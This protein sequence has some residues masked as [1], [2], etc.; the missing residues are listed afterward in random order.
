MKRGARTEIDLE[1]TTRLDA[2]AYESTFGYNFGEF[3]P[4]A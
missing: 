1:V 3:S 2:V 4:S